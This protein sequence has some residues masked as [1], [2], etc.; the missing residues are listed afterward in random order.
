[1]EDNIATLKALFGDLKGGDSVQGMA[2]EERP[3]EVDSK[4]IIQRHIE[5]AKMEQ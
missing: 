1:M 4:A 3:A 2:Q 5:M